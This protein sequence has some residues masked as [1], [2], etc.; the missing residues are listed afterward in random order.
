MRVGSWKAATIANAAASSAEV[1]LGDNFDKLRI[2]LVALDATTKVSVQ[3]VEKAG[4]TP[5]NLYITNPTTG[6]DVQV[7][8]GTAGAGAITWVV[9]LGGFRF[10]KIVAD[11]TQDAERLI[12]VCGYTP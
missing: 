12:R 6:G 8:Q 9:P 2:F 7:I 11:N 3:V 1:D 10:I 4:G 5:Q